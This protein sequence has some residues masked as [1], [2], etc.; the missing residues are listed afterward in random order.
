M[1]II[2]LV[3]CVAIFIVEISSLSNMLK[4]IKKNSIKLT[5]ENYKKFV[6]NAKLSFQS[7]PVGQIK[8]EALEK[9]DL[10]TQS[11]R[12]ILMMY[13]TLFPEN[14]F[15]EG[16]SK[17]IEEKISKQ[18]LDS[19]KT[20]I[21]GLKRILLLIAMN[22]FQYSTVENEALGNICDSTKSK[23]IKK[24]PYSLATYISH[25]GRLSLLSD[26]K[27]IF[28]N[29]ES[30]ILNFLIPAM[31]KSRFSSHGI[32]L[33]SDDKPFEDKLLVGALFGSHLGFNIPY[34]GIGNLWPSGRCIRDQGFSSDICN[35]KSVIDE[36][37]QAGHFFIRPQK[38]AK[39]IST[40]GEKKSL[41]T[42]MLGLESEQPLTKG[43]FSIMAHG[44]RSSVGDPSDRPGVQGG[45]KFE[46]ISDLTEKPNQYGGR[47]LYFEK[48]SMNKI[49]DI[50][51]LL[52]KK[53]D[54]EKE[55]WWI[56]LS[57]NT[58][59]ANMYIDNLFETH[60]PVTSKEGQTNEEIKISG[61]KLD[62]IEK[63]PDSKE[64]DVSKNK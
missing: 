33:G 15:F 47:C 56:L 44:I 46:K 41:G 62:Q 48:N 49:A 51:D 26:S 28:T 22:N 61:I 39:S 1:K 37:S 23:L 57:A 25:G 27:I 59:E 14:M 52:N 11:E 55:F 20:R 34:G 19:N 40:T 50:M 10:K 24:W 6:E 4:R 8:W 13:K 3:L 21:D 38:I 29:S 2:I 17:N 5:N 9:K 42:L 36:E 58:E 12:D 64:F 32:K 43:M 18:E 31:Y 7:R 30:P 45:T 63:F 60:K 35:I 53:K 54:I 16:T